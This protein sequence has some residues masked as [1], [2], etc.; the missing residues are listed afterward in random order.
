MKF[1]FQKHFFVSIFAS[2]FAAAELWF[3]LTVH[4]E[5]STS[6]SGSPFESAMKTYHISFSPCPFQEEDSCVTHKKCHLFL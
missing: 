4:H 6:Q 2:T 1:C 5:T 3:T